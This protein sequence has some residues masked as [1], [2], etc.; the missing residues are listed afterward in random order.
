MPDLVRRLDGLPLA[1]ELAA[2]RTRI[3]TPAQILTRLEEATIADAAAR[4]ERSIEDFR[5]RK[6]TLTARQSAAAARS[7]LSSAGSGI[8]SSLS[9]VNQQMEEAERHTRELEAKAD[10]VDELVAEGIIARPGEDAAELEARRFDAL[11]GDDAPA[12]LGDRKDHGRGPQQ[13]QG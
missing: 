1:L 9:T 10:A 11:L 13:I 6:D 5:L 8:T 4:L 2:A 12:A 3:L 7:Q